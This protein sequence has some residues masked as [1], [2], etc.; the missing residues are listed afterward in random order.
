MKKLSL[1]ACICIALTAC[2]KE[3][4]GT[5]ATTVPDNTPIT[6]NNTVDVDDDFVSNGTYCYLH[7]LN[8]DSIKVKINIEGEKVS[9]SLD[10]IPY[11]KDRAKGTFT[12]T[13]RA[14]GK[15]DIDY[16]YMQEG[17]DQTDKMVFNIDNE[18]LEIENN[19]IY[20]SDLQ[21]VNCN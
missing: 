7:T 18:E 11:Q 21:K 1:A 16:K 15:F 4:N 6:Q 20:N 2:T 10:R 5:P 12:G 13:K 19:P 9:G 17:M 14:D 8:K 3:K